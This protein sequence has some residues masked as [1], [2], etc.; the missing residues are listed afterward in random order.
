MKKLWCFAVLLAVFGLAACGGRNYDD[1]DT[2]EDEWEY[3]YLEKED[4]KED[5][6]EN[7]AYEEPQF[8]PPLFSIEGAAYLLERLQIMWDTDNGEMWGVLL[9]T[10]VVIVC[11]DTQVAVANRPD[12]FD[13]FER[14]YV[15]DFAVY[16]GTRRLWGDYAYRYLG[17]QEGVIAAW[18]WLQSD[19]VRSTQ[20]APGN[21][22][23][24]NRLNHTAFHTLQSSIMGVSGGGG[25]GSGRDASI[26]YILEIS[27]LLEAVIAEGE[28]RIDAI[29]DAL[30]I[31]HARREIFGTAG[32]ENN[33]KIGEGTVVYTEMHLLLSK[34][35]I[36]A[37]ARL[38]P[39]SLAEL[40]ARGHYSHVAQNY[41]Y[42][43]AT[44]YG[45]LL[46]D[47]GVDWRS[48]VIRYSKYTDLG[49]ILQEA[50][51]IEVVPLDEIDL[52]KYG[53][54]DIVAQLGL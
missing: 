48:Y 11:G 53:Y 10:P 36:V 6:E 14:Q 49:L 26:S 18:Q 35:E 28:A 43:S 37:F 44:L 47:L 3:L 23:A 54:S 39:D 22:A 21:I 45:M 40:A 41:G 19:I 46:D 17:G 51:R 30:S 13:E 50:L 2:V 32:V 25:M 27:A 16:V 8:V 34:D 24:L 1:A 42:L 38:W 29:R 52:E 15:R 20:V 7:I 12:G 5:E 31:Y 33:N 9:H 4:S